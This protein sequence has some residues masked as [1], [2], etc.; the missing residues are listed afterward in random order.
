VTYDASDD[1]IIVS[2]RT[3]DCIVKFDHVTGELKW[4]LGD[5]G[6]WRSPWS[7][8]LLK[9]EG[10]L[11]WQYHQHD[12]SVTPA[13]TILCFDNG[14][15][16]AT[17]FATKMP[18]EESYSRIVEFAVDEAAMAVRQVWSYGAGSGERLYGCYQGGAYRLPRTG[19]TFMTYGGVCT[20]DG[21]PTSNNHEGF[22]RARL[23]EVTPEKEIVFDMWIDASDED[24]PVPLSAF[25]SEF[26]PE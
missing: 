2:L 1:S 9:P 13:G 21:V 16:R 10:Q 18:A 7:D 8:K 5:H 19:N 25:R 6:N 3:Q 4:I 23:M 22:C 26:I 20:I 15:F 12:C 24:D 14:N 11:A 17:P